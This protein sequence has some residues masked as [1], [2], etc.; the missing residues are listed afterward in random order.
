MNMYGPSQIMC[1]IVMVGWSTYPFGYFFE[2]FCGIVNP[3]VLNLMRDMIGFI[4]KT[5]FGPMAWS[6]TMNG[7][8]VEECLE[9]RRKVHT[10]QRSMIS[11]D[12]I[13]GTLVS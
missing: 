8:L 5:A 3:R 7:A 1:F 9:S 2:Y 12:E 13:L 11:R 6:C 10:V 4:N